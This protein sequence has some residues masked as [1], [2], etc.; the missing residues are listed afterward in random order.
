MIQA[1]HNL[2]IPSPVDGIC[3]LCNLDITNKAALNIMYTFL[4]T[5]AIFSLVQT[6]QSKMTV[7]HVTCMFSKVVISFYIQTSRM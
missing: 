6:A 7:S 3:V 4:W 2:F 1:G 5:Y